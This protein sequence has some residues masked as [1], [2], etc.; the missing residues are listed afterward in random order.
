ME[1]TDEATMAE[2]SDDTASEETDDTASEETD[3]TARE[4]IVYT[5]TQGPLQYTAVRKVCKALMTTLLAVEPLPHPPSQV[6]NTM[7]SLTHRKRNL[8]G[9]KFERG[10]SKCCLAACH[11]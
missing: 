5:K 10:K 9:A 11:S 6:G 1:G 7:T 2:E 4:E 3:D 8:S